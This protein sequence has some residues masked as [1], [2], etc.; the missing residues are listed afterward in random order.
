MELATWENCRADFA[1]DGALIDILVPGTGPS[2]WGAFWAA[3]RVGPFEL[4][5]FR[6]GEPIPLPESAAWA[7]AERDVA[8]I[9]VSVVAGPLTANCHFFGGDLELDIDPREVVSEPAFESVLAIMK[10]TAIAVGLRVFAVIEGGSPENAFLQVSPVGQVEYL[11]VG[12][13]RRVSPS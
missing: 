4:Q 5:A 3:L 7:L 9:M 8:T 11:P 12:S 13:V 2:E 6:D 1:S 10:F